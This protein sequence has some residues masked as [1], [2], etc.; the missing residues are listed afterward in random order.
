M[1]EVRNSSPLHQP[2]QAIHQPQSLHTRDEGVREDQNLWRALPPHQGFES[3][4]LIRANIDLRLIV[5]H[6]LIVFDCPDYI[7]VGNSNSHWVRIGSRQCCPSE[8]LKDRLHLCPGRNGFCSL[9]TTLRSRDF[10][11]LSAV[12]RTRWSMALM[13]TIG[14]SAASFAENAQQLNSIDAGHNQIKKYQR[15]LGCQELKETF[16]CCRNVAT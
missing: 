6:K 3:N 16:S 8:F 13:M 9:P 11:S 1:P 7:A 5:N 14:V 15:S 12:S 4:H 10:A 2:A